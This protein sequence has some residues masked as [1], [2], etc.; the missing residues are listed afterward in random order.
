M[1][2]SFG[3]YMDYKL[4]ECMVQSE[5]FL[6]FHHGFDQISLILDFN[7]NVR[8]FHDHPY[9]CQRASLMPHK[10][11]KLHQSKLKYC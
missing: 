4:Q 9:N 2:H 6:T 8:I 10:I 11:G 7:I 5:N 1:K 3:H